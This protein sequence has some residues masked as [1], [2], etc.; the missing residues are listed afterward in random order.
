MCVAVHGAVGRQEGIDVS[1][2]AYVVVGDRDM[3]ILIVD[4][5]ELGGLMW[6]VVVSSWTRKRTSHAI[7][8]SPEE[9]LLRAMQ[10]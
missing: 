9:S 7:S 6:W 8:Q 10:R 4:T 2:R 1:A 5:L 3:L